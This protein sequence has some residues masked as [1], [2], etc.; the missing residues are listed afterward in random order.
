MSP[1]RVKFLLSSVEPSLDGSIDRARPGLGSLGLCLMSRFI[2]TDEAIIAESDSQQVS[3]T[4][5]VQFSYSG[6]I[7]LP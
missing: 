3:V 2:R 4:H 5:I 7:I 6:G 1:S